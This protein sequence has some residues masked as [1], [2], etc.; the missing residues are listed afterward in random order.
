MTTMHQ[1]IEILIKE[2]DRNHKKN[3]M[4]IQELKGKITKMKN[5]LQRFNKSFKVI[6]ERISEL[7]NRSIEIKQFKEQRDESWRIMKRTS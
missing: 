2:G 7:K 3:Q 5:S 1:Q 4:E 6:G